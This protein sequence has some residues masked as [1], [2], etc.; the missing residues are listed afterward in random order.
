MSI[1]FSI[2]YT[3]F[4]IVFAILSLAYRSIF[5]IYELVK[6][7]VVFLILLDILAISAAY[8]IR[9]SKIGILLLLVNVICIF[10]YLFMIYIAFFSGGD[11]DR[12]K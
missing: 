2:F 5:I 6:A 10:F 4:H 7:T 8:K 11:W 9:R 3:C 1:K 12:L